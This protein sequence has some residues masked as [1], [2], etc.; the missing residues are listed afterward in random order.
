MIHEL[1]TVGR[2]H[3]RTSR[4]LAAVLNCTPR[5]V[6]R[7]IEQERRKGQPICAATGRN[8]GYFLAADAD[9]LERYCGRLHKRAGEIYKTRRALINVLKQL[10]DQREGA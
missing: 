6:T 3:A 2:E 7:A 1:L 5:D 9:E 4:E 8:P 10:R